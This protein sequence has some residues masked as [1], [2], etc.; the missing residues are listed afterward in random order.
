MPSQRAL[1]GTEQVR[2]PDAPRSLRLAIVG[3][4]GS[5]KSVIAGTMAR[6][7]ARG[8]ERV[9]ALDSD[10][11][12]GL[13]LS[14]GAAVSDTPPLLEAAERGDN[15]RWR[16]RKGIGPARAVH[17]YSTLAPDGVRLLQCG[18][19]AA[20]GLAPIMGAVNAY[21]AVV[22]RIQEV[23]SF[24]DWTF[25]SDLPAG[26]R[27]AAFDWAP[28]ART[29]VL[30]V[31]PTWKSALTA[32]RTARIARSRGAEVIVVAN[33]TTGEADIRAVEAMVAEPVLVGVPL[34]DDVRSA[35][36]L[37]V[38]VLDRAPE[39]AAVSSIVALTE[40]LLR[41]VDGQRE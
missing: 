13:A 21:Y 15:G 23:E 17:R 26:P 25:L 14:L 24:R 3:K 39:S 12:P 31:E 34:D 7:L 36:L 35:E 22:H 2:S 29:Y 27:Q 11:L 6:L 18:K 16:L 32:R 19:T 30:V 9:L 40:Q 8:G 28:F 4:G 38:A 5:G 20:E 37:G 33:K 1:A 41:A 10:L